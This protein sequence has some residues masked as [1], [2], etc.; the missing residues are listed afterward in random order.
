MEIGDLV[1]SE[2]DQ[3]YKRYSNFIYQHYGWQPAPKAVW[4]RIS[5]GIS[6]RSQSKAGIR[7]CSRTEHRRIQAA[8]AAA[9][10]LASLTEG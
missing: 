4:V 1:E 9:S 8:R 10:A 2:L 3:A 5:R 6:T 7:L